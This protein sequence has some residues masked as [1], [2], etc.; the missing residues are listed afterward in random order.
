MASNHDIGL[1]VVGDPA[2]THEFGNN[3]GGFVDD[4]GVVEATFDAGATPVD[5]VLSFD[6]FDI[7]TA[8][9]VEVEDTATEDA[10]EEADAPED[11]NEAHA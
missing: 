11:E 9:E 2:V 1:L 7:D 6:G 8:T 4:D 3:F 10:D 5:L